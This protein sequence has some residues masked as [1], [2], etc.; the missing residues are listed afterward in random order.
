MHS[1]FHNDVVKGLLFVAKCRGAAKE[2]DQTGKVGY[3][4]KD[5][6]KDAAAV[7]ERPAQQVELDVASRAISSGDL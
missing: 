2:K 3:S 6:L 5:K 7:F 1:G 4:R